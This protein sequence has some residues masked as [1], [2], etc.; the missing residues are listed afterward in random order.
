M[1]DRLVLLAIACLTFFCACDN[2]PQQEEESTAPECLLEEFY[3]S[4]TEIAPHF[5]IIWNIRVAIPKAGQDAATDLIRQQLIKRVFSYE[6][7]I[8][9]T[10]DPQQA[11]EMYVNHANAVHT[12]QASGEAMPDYSESIS[13]SMTSITDTMITFVLSTEGYY[14]GAHG[15]HENY[16]LVFDRRTGLQLTDNDIWGNVTKSETKE[17][18]VKALT[19]YAN[20]NNIDMGEFMIDNLGPNNNFYLANDSIYYT[21]NPY[22]IAA[23]CYG[24]QTIGIAIADVKGCRLD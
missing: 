24:Q 8:A 18:L 16:Y 14:G 23:Y 12:Q 6:G 2:A 7:H 11:M 19:R 21:Y 10:D 15:S 4:T 5:N 1:K 20:A 13:L 17:M 3:Y 22:E 9:N